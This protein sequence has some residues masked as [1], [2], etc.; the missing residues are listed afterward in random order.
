MN[1]SKDK[2]N[3]KIIIYY[4][5]GYSVYFC[6]DKL[7]LAILFYYSA[8]FC[9][10]SQ[11][12][13]HF[14]VLFMDPA[15]L[16]QLTFTF[17]YSIFSKKIS[18]VPRYF[19]IYVLKFITSSSTLLHLRFAFLLVRNFCVFYQYQ[20]NSVCSQV[21]FQIYQYDFFFL[22]VKVPLFISF[23]FVFFFLLRFFD[24]QNA[25]LFWF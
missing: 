25:N 7:F 19:Y 4:G 11:A 14:L 1:S 3:S 23:I 12:L 16:F 6:L 22:V 15:V 8:Y 13:L 24:V 17:I 20:C 21:E 10:Y 9:Y 2:L 5:V 18:A